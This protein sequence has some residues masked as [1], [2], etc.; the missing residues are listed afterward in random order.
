MTHFLPPKIFGYFPTPAAVAALLY[1][2]AAGANAH[3]GMVIPSKT[4]LE[5]PSEKVLSIDLAFTHPFEM[6]GMN[7]E[8][9]KAMGVVAN[10]KR[11]NLRDS[12]SQR[13]FLDHAAWRTEYTVER[14][15]IY[16]FH[17][18]PE[19]YF[20]PA[21]DA[22]IIHYTKTYVAALAWRK[23]GTARLGCEPRS[24]RSANPTVC[25]QGMCF[26]A[27]SSSKVRSSPTRKSRWSTSM[28]AVAPSHRPST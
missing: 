19:P 11:V 25:T 28:R 26:K 22:F 6:E 8:K 27:S 21:E 9:P 1:V 14:P 18:E 13:Q 17:M 20:E 7:L 4:M 16:V 15:G 12:L 24:F 23:G 3:F 5:S 10:G 2:F